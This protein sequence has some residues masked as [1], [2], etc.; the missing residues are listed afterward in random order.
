MGMSVCYQVIHETIR[1]ENITYNCY[2]K[3]EE[4]GP[5]KLEYK[6]KREK[7]KNSIKGWMEVMPV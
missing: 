1:V 3:Y 2:P 7:Y 5:S 6:A 4:L